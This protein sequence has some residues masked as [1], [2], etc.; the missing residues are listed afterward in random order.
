MLLDGTFGTNKYKFCLSTLMVINDKNKAIPVAWMI[1]SSQSEQSMKL[2]LDKLAVH[3][4]EDFKPS[5]VIVDDAQAEINAVKHGIWC[6]HADTRKEKE[7]ISVTA[8]A[9]FV[10]P[11]FIIT[12]PST[13]PSH[14]CVH[15]TGASGDARSSSVCGTSS[16]PG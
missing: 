10:A 14:I 5:V 8:W 7:H 3:M 15:I 11:R 9:S 1:H 13:E 6:G 2:M 4:G 16:A 12:A